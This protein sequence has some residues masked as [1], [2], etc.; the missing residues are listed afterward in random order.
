MGVH[1]Y[2]KAAAASSMKNH[3]WEDGQKKEKHFLFS[4]EK[5]KSKCPVC[6]KEFAVKYKM[7][8]HFKATHEG[9]KFCCEK[10][11]AKFSTRVNMSRHLKEL[12]GAGGHPARVS[13][14]YET[15]SRY[16]LEVHSKNRH[17]G[18]RHRCSQCGKEF[19]LKTSLKRH[20]KSIHDWDW[21]DPPL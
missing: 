20:V 5:P 19:T 8:K 10:C 16:K 21:D 11:P 13:C 4:T 3:S 1:R 15:N 12:H 17:E 2:T 6:E 7:V 9:K 18:Q 14:G